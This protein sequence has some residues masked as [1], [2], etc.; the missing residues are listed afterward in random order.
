MKALKYLNKFFYKYRSRLI[1]GILIT[2]VSKVF[3]LQIP[4]LIKESLNI[5]EDYS[6]N[7]ITDLEIVKSQLIIN[8]FYI[9]GAA[10]LAGFFTFLM[11]QTLI[12]MSRLI[13]FDLKNEIFQ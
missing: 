12:V 9:I 13:E 8:I 7:R 5:V 10:L 4:Q 1:L 6:N 11:R 3:A 2:V